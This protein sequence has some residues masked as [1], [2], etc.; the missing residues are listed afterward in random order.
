MDMLNKESSSKKLSSTGAKS[1]ETN[2][3]RSFL[4]KASIGAPV[5]IASASKPAWA[6]N[7]M[8][9]MMSGNTSSPTSTCNTRGG[10]SSFFWNNNYVT[11]QYRRNGN[12]H[13]YY[14]HYRYKINNKYIKSRCK[15]T[16]PCGQHGTLG[17]LMADPNDA[18]SELA[19]AY[20]NADMCDLLKSYGIT[21]FTNYPYSQL[22]IIDLISGV[23]SGSL[24][25]KKVLEILLQVHG[26]L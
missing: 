3:R 17:Q 12:E 24:D 25:N 8:S 21:P 14:L 4:K 26:Q 5:V 13:P 7:C 9:G 6:G 22:D 1:T 18:C 19:A 10:K 23:M 16:T 15:T 2:N 20:I 11:R